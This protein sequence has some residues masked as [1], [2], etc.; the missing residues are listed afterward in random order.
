MKFASLA[1]APSELEAHGQLRL[2]RIAHA[3]PQKAVEVKR[4][5]CSKWVN[6]ILVVKRIEHFELWDHS[7]MFTE[8]EP[9]RDAEVEREKGIVLA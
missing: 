2:A 7:V 3:L 4:I 5:W 1:A 9:A 6:V 8:V